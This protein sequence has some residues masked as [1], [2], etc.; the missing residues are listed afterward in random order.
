[1][2]VP[3][4]ARG[5]QKINRLL[6]GSQ[7]PL[8]GALF[9]TVVPLTAHLLFS[10]MGF[11]P[12][13]DGF[14]LA[15]SRRILEGQIPHLDFITVRPPGSYLLH[16]PFVLL[17]GDYTF[18]LSR[19]FVWFEFATIS[20]CWVLILEGLLRVRFSAPYRVGYGLIG[21]VLSSHTFPP[22]AWNSI[23]GL[24]VASLGL[25][26]ATQRTS[27]GAT[28]VLGYILI[29]SAP[30]FRQNFLL[31][32]LLA[33]IVLGDWRRLR[34][35]VAA[36]AP[37]ALYLGLLVS[38]GAFPD[39]LL[40]LTAPADLGKV[41]YVGWKKYLDH[42]SLPWG[43]L[44]GYGAMFLRYGRVKM[45]LLVKVQPVVGMFMVYGAVA[46]VAGALAY[47]S[48]GYWQYWELVYTLF[49]MSLGATMY[50]LGEETEQR[51]YG[52]AGLL[53]VAFAWSV[54]ISFGYKTPALASG[55]LAL[56]L[57]AFSH[58][59]RAPTV[60]ARLPQRTFPMA[61]A[62]LTFLLVVAALASYYVA[63]HKF[64]YLDRPAEQLTRRLDGVFPGAKMIRTSEDTAAF[65]ED[66]QEAIGRARPKPF[67]IVPDFAGYWVKA[68]QLN[69]LS[70]D[71]PQAEVLPSPAL[72]NRVVEDLERQRG[73]VVVIV[74]KVRVFPYGFTPL[75]DIDHFAIVRYVRSHFEKVGE[76]R[77]FDLYR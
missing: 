40:Q 31:L 66:L 69:P 41:V 5:G 4:S 76:T 42:G 57:L 47:D 51:T 2:K 6:A 73:S 16:T 21:F 30:L 38:M 75:P 44:Y 49:G 29:G 45:P 48:W 70:V 13:D 35:W 54:S 23:D 36:G 77:Y 15:G 14:F 25:A 62:V 43:I 7:G 17:G 26:L 1:M 63:R 53:A 12:T 10:W 8:T 32:P 28:K 74:Q 37:L 61:M 11:N 58:V 68:P 19:L 72:F 60:E 3:L 56:V 18:W 22:M 59:A 9:L 65:L 55:G 27:Q 52:R 20:W 33:L 71:W 34:L 67:A 50:F 39:A 64:V 46:L 24:F